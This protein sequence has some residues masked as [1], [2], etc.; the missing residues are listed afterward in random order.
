MADAP[1]IA[2]VTT[3]DFPAKVLEKSRTLPVLVD[4]WA[5]WCGPCRILTP[6]LEKL[7]RDYDGKFFLAKVNADAERAL[8]AQYG[9]RGLPT[10]ILFRDGAPAGELIGVQP[11]PA[12]RAL[13]DRHLPRQID[14]VVERAWTLH[15][16]G[17]TQPALA[18]L[19]AA[20][21][22][23]PTNDQAKI[24]LARLLLALPLS[25][26]TP[27]QLNEAEQLLDSLSLERLG[28]AQ[29]AALRA[30]LNLLRVLAHAPPLRDLEQKVAIDPDNS[31]A[32]YQL[33]AYKALADDYE[34]AMQH[35]LE[36]VRR[37]RK[38]RD[39]AGRKAMVDLFKL[40]G[41]NNPLVAKYRGLLSK[42]LN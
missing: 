33:S 10:L 6:V 16:V 18:L 11:E 2:D 20:V 38:F 32:R 27:A 12:I 36:I 13:I 21:A 17:Q 42:E 3:A 1:H 14:P 23:K 9:V 30:R 19:R 29:A 26:D 7:A 39:D 4:F 22:A 40:L 25:P 35:L 31:E 34:P 37:D 15:A 28:D 24:E 8:A 41:N 5:A